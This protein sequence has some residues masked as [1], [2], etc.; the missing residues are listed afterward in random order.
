MKRAGNLLKRMTDRDNL[1]LAF[2]KAQKGKQHKPDVI[3]FRLNL[4]KEIR[5]MRRG[6]LSGHIGIGDYHYFTIL[7]PKERLICAASF[8]ERVL[9]HALMNVCEPCFES[10]Q[11]H[12]SYA[13]RKGKGVY[14]AVERARFFRERPASF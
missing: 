4:E 9:H 6:I 7:D 14:K 2:F 13:C 11:V 8:R 10:Y 3:L 5:D 12:D 1:L